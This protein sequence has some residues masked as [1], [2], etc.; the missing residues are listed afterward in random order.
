[1]TDARA[2]T[3]ADRVVDRVDEHLKA[4]VMH[5]AAVYVSLPVL[6]RGYPS[7]TR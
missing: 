6:W 2:Q 5:W 7:L 3:I 4:E 1:M